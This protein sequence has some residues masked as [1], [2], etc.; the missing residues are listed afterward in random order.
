MA[1][2]T[3]CP[4][5]SKE[6]SHCLVSQKRRICDA[7]L[8]AIGTGHSGTPARHVVRLLG[9]LALESRTELLG[10]GGRVRAGQ[11]SKTKTGLRLG[12]PL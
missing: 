9:R 10:S 3:S 7:S 4:A 6:T 12:K 5:R 2:C 8:R 1:L 11:T